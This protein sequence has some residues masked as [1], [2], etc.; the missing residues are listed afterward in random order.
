[1]CTR[2][3]VG[4]GVS[5]CVGGDVSVCGGGGGGILHFYLGRNCL[6]DRVSPSHLQVRRWSCREMMHH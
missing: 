5:V 2:L 1:M 4:G 3:N 6:Y